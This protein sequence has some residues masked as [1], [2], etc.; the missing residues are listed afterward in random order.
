TIWNYLK[1]PKEFWPADITCR[2]I[3]ASGYFISP[4]R[5]NFEA[6]PT[7][8]LEAREKELVMS[9]L[10]ALVQYLRTL[11]IE[12]DLVTLGN[13]SW[14]DPIKK[15]SSLVLDGQTLINLEIFA[16]TFDGGSEGTLFAMLNRCITPFGKRMLRQWVCHPLADAGKINARLDAVDTLMAD[17]TLS[18]NF[19]ASL[20]RIPDLERLISRVHAGRCKAQDFVRVLEG[21]EQIEY[22]ISLLGDFA[23]QDGVIGQLISSMPDLNSRLKQWKDAF[24]RKLAK[25]DGILVPEAGVEED[26]DES[27]E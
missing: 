19:S 3:D 18:E 10:G 21:F 22:T 12:R 15:A 20:S 7:V 13:F 5:D 1:P 17:R 6:W 23:G 24:D 9:A 14:Y 16:N 27:Q 11:K 2:E 26:Y 8:L 4:D 25:Q